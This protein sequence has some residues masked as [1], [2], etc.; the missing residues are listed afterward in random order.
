MIPSDEHTIKALCDPVPW[1]LF[2]YED[3]AVDHGINV[4]GV[5]VCMSRRIDPNRT[6][7]F[8]GL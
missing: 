2:T 6:G 3:M 4:G 7:A 1:R 8:C 5:P